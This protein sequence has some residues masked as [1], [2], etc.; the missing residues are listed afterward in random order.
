MSDVDLLNSDTRSSILEDLSKKSEVRE[1]ILKCFLGHRFPVS[2]LSG[3][4]EIVE[5]NS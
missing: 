1:I 5:C 3:V 4:A 2:A